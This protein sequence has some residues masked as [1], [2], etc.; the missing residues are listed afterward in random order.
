MISVE[1]DFLAR[2]SR[3]LLIEQDEYDQ[4]YQDFPP[5]ILAAAL[6]RRF[7]QT[8]QTQA[9]VEAAQL[10]AHSGFVYETLELCSRAPRSPELQKII[11]KVLPQA[12][13]E[14]PETR[15]IG[16]LLEEAF[17]VIDLT[18]GKIVRFPPLMP[19]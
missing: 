14:Y 3:G 8:N 19:G 4:I 12:R 7:E 11:Q 15:L 13:R 1:D 6:A 2:L 17:I 18:T 5:E 16:K 10:Y 9:L